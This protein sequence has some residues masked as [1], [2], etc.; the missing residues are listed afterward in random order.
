VHFEGFWVDNVAIDGTTISEGDDLGDWMS[1][2]E[3]N[4]VEVEGYTVQ[5]LS[6]D[7]AG[8][9]DAFLFTLPLDASFHGELSGADVAAAIGTDND[10]VA[11]IVTYHDGTQL[12]AQYAPYTLDVN[13]VTQ[14]GG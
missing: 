1:A 7:S 10:V 11:A 2:T 3:F 6:Y 9:G 5:L 8:G 13:G 12:V 4:P 14:P